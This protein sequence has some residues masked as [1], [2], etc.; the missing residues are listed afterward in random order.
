MLNFPFSLQV[1]KSHLQLQIRQKNLFLSQKSQNRSNIE[2]IWVSRIQVGITRISLNGE[3]IKKTLL[4]LC[5]KIIAKRKAND[6]SRT[7]SKI[8]PKTLVKPPAKVKSRAAKQPKNIN[9]SE[10]IVLCITRF[11]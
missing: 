8:Q 3:I 6:S 5:Y 7:V 10:Y 4:F 11:Y 9:K 1:F 2:S